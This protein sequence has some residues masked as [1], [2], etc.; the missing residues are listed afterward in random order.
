MAHWISY[1]VL[2]HCFAFIWFQHF[3]CK[4][5]SVSTFSNLLR[6]YFFMPARVSQ[7]YF[8]TSLCTPFSNHFGGSYYLKWP[9]LF[10]LVW[11]RKKTSQ[12]R[13]KTERPVDYDNRSPYSKVGCKSAVKV[14]VLYICFYLQEG[15]GSKNP[16]WELLSGLWVIITDG[17][18][19]GVRGTFWKQFG[20]RNFSYQFCGQ[21]E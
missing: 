20:L 5:F 10:S 17:E 11:P 14:N 18:R 3:F 7:I 19:K 21:A 15:Q 6:T 2:T 16:L 1:S 8:T 13:T 12:N 9:N 4:Y